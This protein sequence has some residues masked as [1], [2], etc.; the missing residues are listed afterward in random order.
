MRYKLWC[1]PADD[2]P[3]FE[4]FSGDV[5]TLVRI[6]ADIEEDSQVC[7][8]CVLDDNDEWEG[9]PEYELDALLAASSAQDLPVGVGR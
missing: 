7:G 5:L 3:A 6:H 4:V 1:V 8:V 9:L 2:T